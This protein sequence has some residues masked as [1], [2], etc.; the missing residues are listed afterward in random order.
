M[1]P[2][3]QYAAD[4]AD[5]GPSFVLRGLQY[6]FLAG[7]IASEIYLAC[8]A[9]IV[10]G[11]TLNAIAVVLFGHVFGVLPAVI[12][13]ALTGL[14]TSVLFEPIKTT[15]RPVG[16]ALLGMTV[17]AAI[18]IPFAVVIGFNAFDMHVEDMLTYLPIGALYLL[19]GAIGGWRL[20]QDHLHGR[21][22]S[23]LMLALAVIGALTIATALYMITS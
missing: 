21:S 15:L 3:Q 9:V 22:I 23:T 12:L 20:L 7:L 8:Y 1:E 5:L 6:G 10:E 14:A 13:G 19:C 4:G 11:Y 17:A 2:T 16:A 18:L